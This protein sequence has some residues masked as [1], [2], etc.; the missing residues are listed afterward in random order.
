MHF[1]TIAIPYDFKQKRY[2]NVISM[3]VLVLQT[4]GIKVFMF[5]WSP[6][7]DDNR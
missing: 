1:E 5:Q 4:D 3:L 7:N 2:E 6:C